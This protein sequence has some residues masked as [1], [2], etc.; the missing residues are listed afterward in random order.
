MSKP[1]APA[2]RPRKSRYRLSTAL[3]F[4]ADHPG[5]AIL[6][7]KEWV[8]TVWGDEGG[9]LKDARKLAKR[10]VEALNS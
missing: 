3:G 6:D 9:S 2:G 10:I 4:T 7:K 1:T 8:A 5:I